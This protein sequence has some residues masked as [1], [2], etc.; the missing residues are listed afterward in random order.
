M[1]LNKYID[2]T[3]LKA[4]ASKE[5][6]IELCEQAIKW[7][8]YSVCINP[9][10]INTVKELLKGTNVKIATVVGFPLGANMTS[11]KLTEAKYAIQHGVHE[12]D[13]V[14]NISMFKEKHYQFVLGEINKIKDIV[15]NRI[16]KVIVETSYLD[17]DEK[18]DICKLLIDSNA[19]FIKTSTGFS[20]KGAEI[21]DIELFAS[22]IKKNNSDLKIKASG[23]IRTYEKAIAMIN[24]GAN[25]LGTSS[26]VK[27]M[28]EGNVH[29]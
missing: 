28:E 2:H 14:M 19:D 16:L 7:N 25:R 27:I 22:I 1:E 23:G 3:L 29:S 18:N 11:T 8:F 17:E 15:D 21:K 6:I 24:A 26:S 10:W 5:E 13:M 4:N 9:F 20:D 12:I